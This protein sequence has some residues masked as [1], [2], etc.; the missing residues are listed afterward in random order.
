MS[1]NSQENNSAGVSF[2]KVAASSM[3][4]LALLAFMRAFSFSVKNIR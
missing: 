4:L 3:L 1:Q 2:N